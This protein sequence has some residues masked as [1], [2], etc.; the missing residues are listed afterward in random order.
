MANAHNMFI[1]CLNSIYLQAPYVEKEAD[2]KDLLDYSIFWLVI[3]PKPFSLPRAKKR[4]ITGTYGFSGFPTLLN[5][6]SHTYIF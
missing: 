2:I 5:L 3:Q 4:H 1:R 6:L